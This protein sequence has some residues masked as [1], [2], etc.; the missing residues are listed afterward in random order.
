MIVR[1]SRVKVG[2]RQAPH[3]LNKNPTLKVGF[4]RWGAAFR[5][6]DLPEVAH[7]RRARP[8]RADAVPRWRG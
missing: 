1:I 4:L 3:A 5:R 8:I 7:A 2:N 6:L